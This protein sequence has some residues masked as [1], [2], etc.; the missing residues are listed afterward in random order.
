MKNRDLVAVLS[1]DAF[2]KADGKTTNAI[3][4]NVQVDM[5][6]STQK[7]IKEAAGG[8]NGGYTARASLAATTFEGRDGKPRT[9]YNTLYTKAQVQAMLDAAGPAAATTD[10]GVIYAPF[11]ADVIS[12][13]NGNY[14]V[15][16]KT[17]APPANAKPFDIEKHKK[18]CQ[19]ASE[20]FA[21][22]HPKKDAKQTQETAEMAA[23]AEATA[24]EPEFNA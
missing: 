16:T 4:V 6:K 3:G 10:K 22:T 7:A 12:K 1:K 2:D 5:T 8:P 24:G 20:T 17:I 21:K 19:L 11:K 9:G 15:N 23:E 14:S 13:G 18:N